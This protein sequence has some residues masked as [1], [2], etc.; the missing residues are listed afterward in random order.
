MLQNKIWIQ[1][2]LWISEISVCVASVDIVSLWIKTGSVLLLASWES[3]LTFQSDPWT[4][5]PWVKDHCAWSLVNRISSNHPDIPD[6]RG[7]DRWQLTARSHLT[8]SSRAPQKR[9]QIKAMTKYKY[10]Y[11]IWVISTPTPSVILPCFT[12]S[13][14]FSMDSTPW[15]LIGEDKY[16]E[17]MVNHSYHGEMTVENTHHSSHVL[18]NA[19]YM[20]MLLIT[21]FWSYE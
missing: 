21:L 11:S 18:R 13:V 17:K 4:M 15:H 20:Y 9:S 5:Q 19:T 3:C 8:A 2:A 6:S 10:I 7:T 14:S 1:K 12:G 16:R